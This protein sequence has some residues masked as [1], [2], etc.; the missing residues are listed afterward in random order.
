MLELRGFSQLA[1]SANGRWVAYVMRAAIP[2]QG[3]PQLATSSDGSDAERIVL[4]DLQSH[5]RVEV[6]AAGA[7][8]S[9]EWSPAGPTLAFL[10][11]SHGRSSIWQYTPTDSAEDVEP[12]AIPDSIGGS[13]VAFAWSSMGD[14]IAYLAAEP[15]LR[16]R[17]EN[18]ENASPR[19]VLFHDV[20]GEYTEPTVRGYAKD[21]AGAYVATFVRGEKSAHVLVRQLISSEIRPDI[22]WSSRGA[23]L[24][25]GSPIGVGYWDKLTRRVLY[26]LDP[27]TKALR[28][29]LPADGARTVP[30]WSPTGRWIAYLKAQYHSD[31]GPASTHTL[32][33]ESLDRE[34]AVVGLSAE[35]DGLTTVFRPLWGADDG[36]LYIARYQRGTA[37][38]Y[39]V[40]AASREWRALTPDTLSVSRYAVSHDGSVIVA[41]LEN[42]NQPPELFRVD[43]RTRKLTKLTHEADALP[44]MWLGHVDHIS[45]RSSADRFTVHGFLV[46]PPDYHA[47]S[48]Y[49]LVI[50]LHGGPGAQ[51]TNTFA[52]INFVS[53]SVPPQLL[54]A[55]GYLVL[56]PNPRGDPGY[57][58]TFQQAIRGD[59]G[60]GPFGDIDAGVSALI[61]RGLVDSTALG[62][63]GHSYGG[64]LTAYAITHTPRFA[65]ASINDGPVDLASEYGQNYATHALS[66]KWYFGG[67]PWTHPEI[68]AAQSPITHITSVRTPV[69]LRYGGRSSTQD[70]IRQSYMLAQGF[71][72]YAALSDCDVPVQFVLHPDQGHLIDDWSL[73]QDWVLRNLRW[74]DYWLRHRG[75]N[76]VGDQW[77]D[78]Y[79]E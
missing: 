63:A 31:S 78:R 74:F 16:S 25:S 15:R 61:E 59:W 36:H 52:G 27:H 29:L 41:V 21:P 79:P 46:K 60:P 26:T 40:D 44:A 56:L 57:G 28:R 58:R 23:L 75:R 71:E 72:L 22:D 6:S 68:Y 5:R 4:L 2:M 11:A 19:S 50:Q 24:V 34:N 37:R 1:V 76:P 54:A 3:A 39:I 9:L 65:A 14:T 53:Q 13:I 30:S 45:W 33:V 66:D 49:P 51:Y 47:T 73:Y 32:Q 43:V 12:L 77:L 67:T 64:Y 55:A 70:D 35:S 62:I 48:R 38:L 10:V 69:L 8:R 20:P 7:P 17:T 18:V 42:A